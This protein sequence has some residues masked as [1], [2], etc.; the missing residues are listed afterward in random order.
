MKTQINWHQV[1][2]S[3]IVLCLN[4]AKIHHLVS[5]ASSLAQHWLAKLGWTGFH[6]PAWRGP[7]INAPGYGPRYLHLLPH[8]LREVEILTRRDLDLCSKVATP[9][10]LSCSFRVTSPTHTVSYQ[11][12]NLSLPK[13]VLNSTWKLFLDFPIVCFLSRSRTL[14]VS[15]FNNL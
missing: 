10:N 12:L 4:M 3:R 6:F 13:M 7:I 8:S 1:T 2:F 15:F 11:P 5:D 9:Q 14:S